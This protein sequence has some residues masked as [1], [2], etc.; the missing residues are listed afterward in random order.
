MSIDF[1][2]KGLLG[3][4]GRDAV[5]V[6]MLA[7]DAGHGFE[8]IPFTTEPA[9][10]E[11][12]GRSAPPARPWTCA[13]STCRRSSPL[14]AERLQIALKPIEVVGLSLCV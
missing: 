13:P 10:P 7:F 6:E 3:E 1:I 2:K 8:V 14:A 12:D 4:V 11:E 5:R 9:R